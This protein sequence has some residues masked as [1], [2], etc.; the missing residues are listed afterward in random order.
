MAAVLFDEMQSKR[1]GTA[2]CV[3]TLEDFLDWGLT[4]DDF[5]QY[6]G[7][8][9]LL[10]GSMITSQSSIQYTGDVGEKLIQFCKEKRLMKDS[11]FSPSISE[12]L[13]RIDRGDAEYYYGWFR[14]PRSDEEFRQIVEWKL[15]SDYDEVLGDF[16]YKNFGSISF[17]YD[18]IEKSGD[19][20]F[21]SIDSPVRIRKYDPSN[22]SFSVLNHDEVAAIYDLAKEKKESLEKAIAEHLKIAPPENSKYIKEWCQWCNTLDKL[23]EEQEHLEDVYDDIE[24]AFS[25]PDLFKFRDNDAITVICGEDICEHESHFLFDV[26]VNLSF[27]G[28]VDKVVTMRRCANCLQF[29]MKVEELL[30][31]FNDY[32]VPRC[33]IRYMGACGDFSDFAATSIFYDMGY[34][35][36]QPVGLSPEKRQAILKCAIDM[37]KASKWEVMSF[38]SQRMNINGMKPGNES[39]YRKWKEDY[40][41]IRSLNN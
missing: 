3:T 30:E 9:H 34:S 18:S 39:A 23:L 27:Y 5:A 12:A 16:I 13:R 41:Y 31:L 40:E 17:T 11:D 4:P 37:G 2:P 25:T 10:H 1:K 35:V 28:K 14:Y 22:Q 24:T 26:K 32:G 20:K 15:S 29:Q 36:S 6:I 8:M 38:L 19:L 21:V 7:M 33:K